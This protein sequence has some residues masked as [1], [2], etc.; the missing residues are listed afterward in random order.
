MHSALVVECHREPALLTIYGTICPPYFT[1]WVVL[2]PDNISNN[3]RSQGG[4]RIKSPTLRLPLRIAGLRVPYDPGRLP[5][6]SSRQHD[7]QQLPRGGRIC[8]IM[9]RY[10]SGGVAVCLCSVQMSIATSA[11]AASINRAS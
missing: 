11:D 7:F 4:R 5:T 2:L 10:G 6:N 9:S 1:L 8:L 3:S